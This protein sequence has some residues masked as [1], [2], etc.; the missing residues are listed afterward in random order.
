MTVDPYPLTPLQLQALIGV[1]KGLNVHERRWQWTCE[2]A[3]RRASG[4][5]PLRAFPFLPISENN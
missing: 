3:K 2:N 5:E 4:Q 1:C